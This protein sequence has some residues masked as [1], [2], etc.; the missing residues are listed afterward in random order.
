MWVWRNIKGLY[1]YKSKRSIFLQ[2]KKLK[3]TDFFKKIFKSFFFES[4]SK[5]RGIPDKP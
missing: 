5:E 4:A 3:K 1:R 2:Q